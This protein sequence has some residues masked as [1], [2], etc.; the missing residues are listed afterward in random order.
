MAVDQRETERRL[1]SLSATASAASQLRRAKIWGTV[2]E[3][4]API[5]SVTGMDLHVVGGIAQK[6]AGGESHA[7][8]VIIGSGVMETSPGGERTAQMEAGGRSRAATAVAMRGNVSAAER[9]IGIAR[10][11]GIE[12]PQERG[13]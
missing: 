8:T 7:L 13:K 6:T 2:P 11:V 9:M 12:N 3:T 4:S 1:A 5:D 10:G